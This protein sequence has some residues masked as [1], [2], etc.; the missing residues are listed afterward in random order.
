MGVHNIERYIA[1]HRQKLREQAEKEAQA[2]KSS[3]STSTSH[4]S[5]STTRR[6]FSG[7]NK[8]SSKSKFDEVVVAS[9]KDSLV[10]LD[11]FAT[12]CGPCKMIAPKVV[13]LSNKYENVAFTKFDVDEV[14]EIAQELGVRAMPTFVFFK[15]G[16]K[17]DEMVG[18]DPRKL[19]EMV[20]KYL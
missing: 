14:P 13:E 12:W 9:S 18:A 2:Q 17:V 5:S 11:C 20:Q 8:I 16:E 1:Y 15:G 4:P 3:Y 7:V 19:E 6:K 10:V